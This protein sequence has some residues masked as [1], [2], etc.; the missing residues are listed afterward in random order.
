MNNLLVVIISVLFTILVIQTS[1][2]MRNTLHVLQKLVIPLQ[3]ISV[4]IGKHPINFILFF[5]EITNVSMIKQMVQLRE[6]FN[7]M[8]I[9]LAI[10][11][12]TEGFDPIS[13][14]CPGCEYIKQ[15][16]YRF[17]PALQLFEDGQATKSLLKGPD[18]LKI[19]GII[20]FIKQNPADL[21]YYKIG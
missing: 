11:N 7:Q 19:K 6:L 17:L 13:H 21:Q 10:V 12:V 18:E 8:K 9:P 3:E 15:F 5:D 14:Y 16:D 1:L 4:F 20:E 2:K